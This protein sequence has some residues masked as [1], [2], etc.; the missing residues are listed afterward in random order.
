MKTVVK[1]YEDE[2]G[3]VGE[4]LLAKCLQLLSQVFRVCFKLPFTNSVGSDAPSTIY[5]MFADIF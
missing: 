5:F 4:L 1:T 3:F 2:D